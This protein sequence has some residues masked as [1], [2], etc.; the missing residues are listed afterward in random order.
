M[1]TYVC[2][3]ERTLN[4]SLATRPWK[5]TMYCK[6]PAF[7]KSHER[8]PLS[9]RHYP[10]LVVMFQLDRDVIARPRVKQMF[11]SVWKRLSYSVK[12]GFDMMA[13][14]GHCS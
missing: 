4:M 13:V 1:Y 3:R 2:E 10:F 14:V 6:R 7:R 12:H 11:R 5:H 8:N 9:R